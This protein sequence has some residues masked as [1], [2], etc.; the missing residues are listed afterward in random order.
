MAEYREVFAIDDTWLPAARE[1]CRRH[2]LREE[3]LRRT[4]LGSNPVFRCGSTIIKLF[5][6]LWIEQYAAERAGLLAAAGLPVPRITATGLLEDWPYLL[7]SVVEGV[8]ALEVWGTLAAPERHDIAHQIGA[9]LALLHR[10][11]TSIDGLPGDWPG[12]LQARIDG[13]AAHHAAEEPWRGWIDARVAAFQP[14]PMADVVLHADVTEDHILLR[15]GADGWQICGLIDFGDARRGHPFYDFIA[16]LAFYT[17]GDPG[18]A[19]ALLTGYGLDTTPALADELTTWCL[20]HEYGRVR[21]FVERCPVA[22][23]AAFERALWGE[24]FPADG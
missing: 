21:D 18:A 20:L 5:P 11:P 24:P 12:F 17:F 6:S 16:P 22:A 7:M 14:T 2:G 19:R 10:C 3:D 4:T 9:L 15:Q 23:G 13:A 1:L 8:P